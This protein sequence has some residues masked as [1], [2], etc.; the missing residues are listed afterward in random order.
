MQL[1]CTTKIGL[2]A[3]RL[4]RPTQAGH[5]FNRCF[6]GNPVF[7]EVLRYCLQFPVLIDCFESSFLGLIVKRIIEARHRQE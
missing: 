5:E 7:F 6:Q 1:K 3:N 4:A 2:A